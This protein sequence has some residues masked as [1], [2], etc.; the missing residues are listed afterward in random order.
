MTEP[1]SLNPPRWV[2]KSP[3]KCVARLSRHRRFMVAPK[4]GPTESSPLSD[5]A[6]AVHDDAASASGNADKRR[7]QILGK[8]VKQAA[9]LRLQGNQAFKKAQL[10]QAE[11]KYSQAIHMLQKVGC[12]L[13]F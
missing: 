5:S 9:E 10:D 12:V 6:T 8:L 11:A 4:Y 1:L 2:I 3:A 13:S 7:Q